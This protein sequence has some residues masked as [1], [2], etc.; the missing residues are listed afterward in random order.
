MLVPQ[1]KLLEAKIKYDGQAIQEI[2]DYFGIEFNEKSKSALCPFHADK[3]PS[4]SWNPKTASFRCFGC[5]KSFD[6]IDL[7]LAQGM[8]FIQAVQ[9]L[10]EQTNT[11]F[12]FSPRGVHSKP[13][14]RYPKREFGADRTGVEQYMAQRKISKKTLDYADIQAD[15]KGNIVFHYYD[16][17]DVLL[18]VKYRPSRKVLHGENKMWFQKDTD[19]TPIL[20]NMNRIDPTKPLVITEGCIDTLSVIE[21]GYTNVVSVPNGSNSFGWIEENWEWL[22]QFEKVIIWSDNDEPGLK[23]RNECTRRLGTWRTSYIEIKPEDIGKDNKICKDANEILY[24]YGKERVME[25]INNPLDTPIQGVLDLVDAEEFD[26]ESAEGLYT[27]IKELDDKIYKLVFGTVVLV[28]GKSGSGKSSFANQVA[29]GEAVNQGYNCFVYSGELPAPIL[30]NWV[31]TNMI[32]RE[33]ITLKSNQARV[34]NNDAKMQMRDWYKGRIM[35]YDDSLGVDS[36]SLLIKMEEAVRKLGCRVITI[37]NLMCVDLL[38]SENDRLE[39]EKTFVKD[40]VLFAKKFNVLIFLLAHPRKNIAGETSLSLQSISGASAIG[41]LCH[42]AFAVHRY[43][44]DEKNGETNMRGDYIKG[45]EPKQYDTYVEVIK[46]RLTGLMPK[47]ELYFDFPSYRFYRTPNEL[48]K[49]YKWN[50][51]TSPIRTDDPNQ[52][53]LTKECPLND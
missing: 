22:E 44:N 30:K 51:D 14:Y 2:C 3:N 35:V 37:D 6:I 17:N 28:T 8:T 41:N 33:N 48:W 34:F 4:F 31:E 1:D 25:Y 24:F 16:T 12:S 9:K 21:A 52:H 19:T 26:I 29:I 32:G 39:A 45:K 13:A 42:M 5:S 18:N 15:E 20:F 46:N 36:K 38:C 7:Y 49:R 50:K 53:L 11:D 40:L 43:T 47:I 23:M 10:F 27:G